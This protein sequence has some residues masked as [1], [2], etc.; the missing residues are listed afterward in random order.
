MSGDNG[1]KQVKEKANIWTPS[2]KF[3]AW[4]DLRLN[5]DRPMGMLEACKEAGT[6]YTNIYKLLKKPEYI[7][8]LNRR[9]E[10]IFKAYAPA[11]DSALINKCLKGDVSAIRLFHELYGDLKQQG[12]GQVNIVLPK[13]MAGGFN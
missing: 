6:H 4:A 13:E 9:R 5:P 12:S 11:V 10:E 3:K 7:E 1:D 8:Y 2:E